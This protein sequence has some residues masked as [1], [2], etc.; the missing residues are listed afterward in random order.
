V[1]HLPSVTKLKFLHA[2]Q[3]DQ[4]YAVY[5]IGVELFVASLEVIGIYLTLERFETYA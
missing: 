3:G 1:Q 2:W 5:N 4:S